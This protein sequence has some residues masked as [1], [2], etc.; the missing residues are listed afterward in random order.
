MGCS[1]RERFIMLRSILLNWSVYI[2]SLS[3]VYLTDTL[4][5][6]A[7]FSIF[8]GI[9]ISR[10]FILGHELAHQ[11]YFNKRPFSDFLARIVLLPSLVPLSLWRT[12]HNVLHHRYT[13][14]KTEDFIW[15]PLS[16]EEYKDLPY[17]KKQ[18]YKIYRSSVGPL[19]YILIEIWV[20]RFW[21][22]FNAL[23]SKKRKYEFLKDV[24]F[25]YLYFALILF[26]TS[27]DMSTFIFGF[28]VPFLMFIF[29]FGVTT[30]IQHTNPRTCWYSSKED[31]S[32]NSCFANSVHWKVS[33]FINKH[34][35]FV[36]E[37][38]SHHKTISAKLEDLP[39]LEKKLLESND[40]LVVEEFS[41]KKVFE[42]ISFCQIFDYNNKKWLSFKEADAILEKNFSLFKLF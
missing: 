4:I 3:Y 30:Y 8:I 32:K 9:S 34:S 27:K 24:V 23:S 40:S 7:I 6:K 5:L 20:K 18:I 2:A 13:N 42:I 21:F 22:P 12:G 29:L 37:H 1:F 28:L 11:V 38:I 19:V 39:S 16:L 31:W 25:V 41:W 26:I 33:S 10:L 35:Y 36:M 15:A 17:L 14:L